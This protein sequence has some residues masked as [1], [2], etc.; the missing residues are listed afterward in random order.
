[1]NMSIA[2]QKRSQLLGAL[3]GMGVSAPAKMYPKRELLNDPEHLLDRMGAH[4]CQLAEMQAAQ[5]DNDTAI[6]S[7]AD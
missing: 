3:K 5:A 1:M 2:T 7:E 6:R 4:V